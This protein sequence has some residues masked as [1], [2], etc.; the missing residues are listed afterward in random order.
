MNKTILDTILDD[1]KSGSELIAL[2]NEVIDSELEKESPN[3][4]LIDEC[5]NA[6]DEMNL[7][8]NIFPALK[9]ALTKK[10]VIS[11]CRKQTM[12]NSAL[13]PVIAA[14]LALFISG[15][16]AINTSPALAENIKNFFETIV[17][18]VFEMADETGTGDDY[19][20][21]SSIY[22][23]L[24]ENYNPTVRGA[25]NVDL[26]ELRVYAVYNDNTEFEIDASKCMITKT[27]EHTDQG[28]FVLVVISYE[29]CSCSMAFQMEE[30]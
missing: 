3:C 2:L 10:Q 1:E 24:P 5:I 7:S 8:F 6:I 25:E 30:E 9:L 29:G 26:S 12:R 14:C 18:A 11:Y 4:D 13:K 17:A 20:E 16:V 21:L 28:N 27:V 19:T 15:A 23:T 22:A